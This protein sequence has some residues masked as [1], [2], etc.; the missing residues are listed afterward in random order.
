MEGGSIDDNAICLAED[1]RRKR[2]V[3]DSGTVMHSVLDKLHLRCLW[4]RWGDI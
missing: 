3:G 2:V 1:H 4:D